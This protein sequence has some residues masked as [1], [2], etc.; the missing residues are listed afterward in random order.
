M[1]AAPLPPLDPDDVGSVAAH[2][3][4][5][6]SEAGRREAY[7]ADIVAAGQSVRLFATAHGWRELVPARPFAAVEILPDA[8]A[9]W[10][11]LLVVGEAPPDQLRPAALPSAGI[12]AERLLVLTDAG[13]RANAP[14]HAALPD[15]WSRL[16]AHE[17]VHELHVAVLAAAGRTEAAMGPRWFFEG[18]AVVGSGQ[19]FDVH[20]GLAYP[21]VP[22]ALADVAE[23]DPATSYRRYAAAVRL[24]ARKVPLPELVAR[25][26]DPDFEG[27]LRSLP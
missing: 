21:D 17:L 8:E 5:P 25:A 19:D 16:V 13:Y 3:V 1:V 18:L 20:A 26:G 14:Q 7:A 12:E 11:R 23:P 24:L 27:W 6:E 9:L 22:S 15:A 2:L 4:L 10:A